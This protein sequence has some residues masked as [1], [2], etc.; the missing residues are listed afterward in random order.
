M[1]LQIAILVCQWQG[2]HGMG[3]SE[4]ANS[5]TMKGKSKGAPPAMA[6]TEEPISVKNITI[7]VSYLLILLLPS[8]ADR[9]EREL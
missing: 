2:L 4:V 8:L 1:F 5:E 9:V 6:A 3:A 7:D